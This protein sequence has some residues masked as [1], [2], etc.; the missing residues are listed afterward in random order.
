MRVNNKHLRGGVVITA[1]LCATASAQT[2]PPVKSAALLRP[3]F[4]KLAEL[5]NGKGG[6]V[7]IVHIG[8]S[9]IQADYF[10]DAVRAPLQRRFGDGGRGFVFPYSR[11]A[12]T[13]RPYRF[14]TNAD[15]RVCRNNQPSRCEPG[16]E[17][18]LSGYGFGTK[19]KLFALSVEAN[20]ERYNFN[21][22]KVISATAS[23]YRLAAVEGDKAPIMYNEKHGIVLHKVK[24]GE[25]LDTIAKNYNVFVT[26]IKK[27]NKL[28]ADNVQAG[29]NLRIPVTT[30]VSGVD[31]SM[32]RFVKYKLQEPFILSYHQDTA[33][34]AIY[35]LNARK[36]NLYCING[37]IV[38][39]DAPGVVY[40]NIGT[41]GAMA[42]HFNAT[43]L[44]F[45]Q[46][47]VLN[48]DLVIVS[49]GTNESYGELSADVF[50]GALEALID[51]IKM[52]CRGVPI[53]ITTPPFSLLRN[54]RWN[55]YI[56]DYSEALSRK[57]GVAVW[58]LYAFTEGL[59]GVNDNF[60]ALKINRDNI[61]Y[62]TEGYINQGTA[63]ADA[64]LDS[65]NAYKRGGK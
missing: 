31:T 1:M 16:T 43:P 51:N 61:H 6:K 21:T 30:T 2:P 14:A 10:T 19:A 55:T 57:V 11:N 36:Q 4:E 40:H 37:L 46:L 8:D 17:F 18:G 25:T 23:S 9:H 15:W 45:Q 29:R 13:A 56:A 65:Y 20:E 60:A 53:L 22:V 63:F 39:N 32:F 26:D 5:E 24:N 35:V 27:E 3:F 52:Y 62:T 42:D 41:T 7:N 49:F 48:P 34:S 58:D 47:P 38:E 54:K 12:P 33:M 50:M 28:K 59:I 64:L 44:F